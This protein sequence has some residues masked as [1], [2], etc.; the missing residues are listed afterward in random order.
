MGKNI[1]ASIAEFLEYCSTN[2]I[3]FSPEKAA[4]R[5]IRLHWQICYGVKIS[6]RDAMGIQETMFEINKQ[7][8]GTRYT[9][10][11]DIFQGFLHFCLANNYKF[12]RD[13]E[14]SERLF[15][16]LWKC[17]FCENIEIGKVVFWMRRLPCAKKDIWLNISSIEDTELKIAAQYCAENNIYVD[18]SI[19]FEKK[20]KSYWFKNFNKNI[21][22][23]NSCFLKYSSIYSSSYNEG[24]L[25]LFELKMHVKAI[26]KDLNKKFVRVLIHCENSLLVVTND[27]T[28]M[29]LLKSKWLEIFQE[30]LSDETTWAYLKRTFSKYY[31]WTVMLKQNFDFVAYSKTQGL[32]Y[33]HGKHG[34]ADL[35]EVWREYFG[36]S[37]NESDAKRLL[38]IIK[39]LF[40]ELL[41]NRSYLLNNTKKIDYDPFI[42]Y[43]LKES[44]LIPAGKTGNTKIQEIWEKVFSEKISSNQAKE[45][46]KNIRKLEPLL[47]NTQ[48]P[49]KKKVLFQELDSLSRIERQE[50]LI[51]FGEYCQKYQY[52]FI[53]TENDMN[54][55]EQVWNK[56]FGI[57]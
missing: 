30:V 29:L 27:D 54:K 37:I 39:V 49:Q 9:N 31:Y 4:I 24:A 35:R 8:F 40:P 42:L 13:L 2:K 28:G 23:C 14:E 6:L 47:M 46:L 26:A 10:T 36:G 38:R 33:Q 45:R 56:C 5:Q 7:L 15:Q 16:K 41:T 53:E 32:L 21:R 34:I 22:L 11:S 1:T 57:R 18:S 55:I 51:I 50:L 44:I 48:V 17:Y 19:P 12:Q 43:C 20:I 52:V 3:I 25:D